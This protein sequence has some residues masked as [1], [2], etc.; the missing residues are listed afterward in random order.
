MVAVFIIKVL[1]LFFRSLFSDQPV[2]GPGTLCEDVYALQCSSLST[3]KRVISFHL[4][5]MNQ[6]HFTKLS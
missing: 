3:T 6:M 2:S 4:G 5:L 1:F